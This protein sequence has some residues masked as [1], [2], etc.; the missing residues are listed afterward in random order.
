MIS[1]QMKLNRLTL[2]FSGESSY[3][4]EPFLKDYY[5]VSLTH[6]RILLVLGALL[7]A[8]F[9]VLDALVMPQQM[10]TTWLIRLVVIGPGLIGVLLLS[11]SNLFEKY[12]QPILAFAYILA[13]LGILCM[14]VVAPPPVSYSYY[15]GLMLVFMWGYALIRLFFVWASFAGWLQVVLYELAAFL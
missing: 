7:Y 2:K 9:G 15:A 11:F 8:A 4:E 6:V 14:I 13:G 5:K 10:Y 1:Q 12:M 3:L